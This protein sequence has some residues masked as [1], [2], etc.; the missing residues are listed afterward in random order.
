MNNVQ[1]T[2]TALTVAQEAGAE[3]YEGK[4]A[5][6]YVIRNR[7]DKA[8]CSFTDVCLKP[9]QFS[10]W[11]NDSPTRMNIDNIPDKVMAE[12]T[13]AT[14]AAMYLLEPDPTNGAVFYLN[15]DTVIATA[16]KLPDWWA[17]DGEPT[18]TVNIGRHLFRAKRG[19]TQV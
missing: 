3:S 18:S 1:I 17:I 12:C 10:C 13:K 14:I 19:T 7:A 15:P 5:V 4:L 11:N 9:W 6:A 8:G 16:G 2:I